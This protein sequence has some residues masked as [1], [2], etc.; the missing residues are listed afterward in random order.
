VAGLYKEVTEGRLDVRD[1][2][3]VAIVTGHGLK[4]PDTITSRFAAPRLIPAK[5]GALAKLL[6]A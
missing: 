4:D 1:Q 6:G 2:T 5:Y 3:V